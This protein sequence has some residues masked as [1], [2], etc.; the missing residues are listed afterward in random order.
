VRDEVNE[1]GVKVTTIFPGS[2]ATPRQANLHEISGK[3]YDPDRLLQPEDV[4]EAVLF[5]LTIGR[6]AEITE[7]HLR[8][9]LKPVV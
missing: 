9:V 1:A 3:P 5:A 8:P 2:T 6:T 7:L 4:A